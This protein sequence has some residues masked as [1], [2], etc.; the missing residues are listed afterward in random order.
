[1]KKS[2]NKVVSVLIVL[3]V[4]TS[5]TVYTEKQSQALSRAVYATRDSIDKARIDLAANY[6]FEATRIVKPPKKKID[7]QAVYKTTT[8][9]VIASSAKPKNP[10]QV[11]KQRVVVVPEQ[12]KNDTVIVVDSEEYQQLLKDK[13]LAERLKKENDQLTI[14]K[15]EVDEELAKQ[16]EYANKMIQDL[17]NMQQQ[18]VKKNLHILKLYIVIVGLILTGA[19]GIYLRMKG[20]L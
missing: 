4:F 9:P 13:Q 8:V 19:A 5:C 18:L 7:I 6:S 16:Q 20:I 14:F 2:F 3:L 12:Y 10:I 15:T 11:N 17:N 1:M